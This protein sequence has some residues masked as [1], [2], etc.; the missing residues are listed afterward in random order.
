MSE[1]SVLKLNEYKHSKGLSNRKIAELTGISQVSVDNIFSGK[2]KNPTVNSLLKLARIFDCAMDDLIDYD[3][4]S[5][6][7][8]YYE[9][10]TANELAAE[11]YNNSDLNILMTECKKLSSSDIKLLTI[12]A[13]RLNL[14]SGK[15]IN[16]TA[17]Q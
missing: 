16:L 6:L 8:G 7:A 10:K 12:V 14:K 5:P 17:N 13:E 3:K 11:I 9:A 15:S 1:L 4:N 2:N